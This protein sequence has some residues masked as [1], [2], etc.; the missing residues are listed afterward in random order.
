M[1]STLSTFP[2]HEVQ[3]PSQLGF[4]GRPAAATHRQACASAPGKDSVWPRGLDL[5][6][7]GPRCCTYTY[8]W[9]YVGIF[10]FCPCITH[11]E[12]HALAK[13]VL[14]NALLTLFIDAFGSCYL[15]TG[16]SQ[17]PY[18]GQ[19]VKIFFVVEAFNF[20]GAKCIYAK[21]VR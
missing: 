8:R 18:C 15:Y 20:A 14:S 19:L 3:V 12:M 4:G 11:V 1:F 7:M 16:V 2:Y 13:A 6:G 17:H 5:Q 21:I 10:A 9:A